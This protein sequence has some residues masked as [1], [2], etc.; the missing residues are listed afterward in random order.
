M[1]L[2]LVKYDLNLFF[3]THNLF[4]KSGISGSG[5]ELGHFEY[6]VA[7]APLSHTG[8]QCWR[9]AINQSERGSFF[10]TVYC[11]ACALSAPPFHRP[12]EVPNEFLR[13]RF[14]VGCV[15]A[16]PNFARFTENLRCGAPLPP[17]ASVGR[18]FMPAAKP[19]GQTF[20]FP[21]TYQDSLYL[22]C[23]YEQISLCYMVRHGEPVCKVHGCKVFSVFSVNFW[24][25]PIKNQL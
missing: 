14:R 2:R 20:S 6:G 12:N 4:C 5:S 11:W 24:T 15:T 23:P 9:A 7:T 8:N 19:A 22:A 10:S 25:V 21:I 1:L 13:C 16:S 17:P 3:G 18:N